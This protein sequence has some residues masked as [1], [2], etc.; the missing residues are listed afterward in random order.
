MEFSMFAPRYSSAAILAATVLAAHAASAHVTFEVPQATAGST[1]KAVLRVPHGCEGSPTH[2]VRIKLPSGITA[3]KPQPKPG[4]S[5]SSVKG[6]LATPY[7]DGHG[8][9]I[10]EGIVEVAWTGGKLLD[11]HFDEFVVRIGLPNTPNV[12]LSFPT[13]Q[14]CEKGVHRWIEIPA[15]GKNADDYKEPAPQLRL[16]PK[17]P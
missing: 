2:T 11:E 9:T 7:T 17:A 10:T 13:V 14:E 6:K 3:A 1:Y 12:T 15:A 8:N 16:V 5:V 4:W